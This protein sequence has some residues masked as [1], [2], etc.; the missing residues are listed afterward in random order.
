MR[1]RLHHVDVMRLRVSA[2]SSYLTSEELTAY[3]DLLTKNHGATLNDK[4]G[5]AELTVQ[6]MK[7]FTGLNG[8]KTN[9]GDDCR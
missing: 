5:T 6:Q 2:N 4:I 8:D 7:T 3:I 9:N 1:N